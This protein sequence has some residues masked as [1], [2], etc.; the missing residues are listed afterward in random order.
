MG[1]V[2][3]G[4]AD[5]L[6]EQRNLAVALFC[7]LLDPTLDVTHGVE[8][9]VEFC[10]VSRA[11]RFLQTRDAVADV[12]QDAAV[13]A[14]ASQP[15]RNIGAIGRPDQPL[16]DGPRVVLHRERCR[17]R[18]PGDRVGVGAAVARIAGAERLDRIDPEFERR[19]LRFLAQELC[20][21]LVHRHAGADVESLGLLDVYAGQEGRRGACVVSDP[22]AGEWDGHLVGKP[23]QYVDLVAE[24]GERL[25]DGGELKFTT[26]T[27][28]GPGA[29]LHPIGHIADT[30]PADRVG[31]RRAERRIGGHHAVSRN[32]NASEAPRP[33]RMVRRG[34]R[35]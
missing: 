23:T 19:Q 11:E 22:F 13:L 2:R 35:F 26:V 9:L 8:I 6:L 17:R 28:W 30:K 31:G 33:R 18:A 14:D 34:M 15:R 12:V 5:R 32:G 29:H 16:E 10:A 1:L 21:D 25:E 27:L 20:R 7:R 3:V 24:W 4:D